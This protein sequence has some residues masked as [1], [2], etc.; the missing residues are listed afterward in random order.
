MSLNDR[1]YFQRKPALFIHQNTFEEKQ[2]NQIFTR[3]KKD[4]Y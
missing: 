3:K 1:D 4:L 2:D